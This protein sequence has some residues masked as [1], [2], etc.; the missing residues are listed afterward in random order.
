M[1]LADRSVEE[2]LNGVASSA[3][4][5][6]AGA[7]A[8]VSAASGAALCEM[9][10]LHTIG[11][12]GY[13]D[14]E[15]ELRELVDGLHSSRDRLLELAEADA[16][17][18][19]GLVTGKGPAGT[20][21]GEA[22]QHRLVEIP[23]ETAEVCRRVLRFARVAIETG[24]ETASEDGVTGALL[25]HAAF[26]SSVRLVRANLDG[27]EDATFVADVEERVGR[28]EADADGLLERALANT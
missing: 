28:L 26:G 18:V 11:K 3:V 12:E 5:P 2:F 1:T 24:T 13:A 10:C 17:A 15:D 21:E 22:A 23:L 25:V 16:R 6:S 14:A 7:V 9:V 8:A 4:T 27:I 20:D 19:D